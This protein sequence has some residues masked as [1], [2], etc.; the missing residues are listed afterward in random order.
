MQ[1][2]FFLT[3]Q[4][5]FVLFLLIVIGF[6]AGRVNLISEK[7]QKDITQL[8]LYITMPATIFS[9]MQLEMN[10]E[11]LN[12]SFV[13]LGVLIF[14]YVVMFIAG[15][16]VSRR[17]SLSKGQKDIFQTALLLSNTSFMGYPIILSLLGPDALFYA[18]VGAG[19]IFEIVSWSVGVYLISRN[20]SETTGFNWKKV[21]FSPGI[22]SI[23][24]GLIF[25]IFQWSV[26]EPLNSVIDTMSPATSP[27]AMIVIG[28]MLSRSNINEAF[29]NKYLYIAAAF[30]L[31]IV[32]FII[33]MVLKL[34]GLT[35]PALV[36]PAMMISMPTA[37]YVAMFSNNYGNDAKFASQIV[38]LSSL[39][40]MISIPI[41]TL[42]F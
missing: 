32:P 5:V 24:I 36:I 2:D 10:Q 15:F 34:F 17:L 13:I 16:L 20:G 6:I 22:L 21:L 38:F 12:T 40:S 19:F 39:M 29:K 14:C 41:I 31:L 1:I 30:K 37:S 3:L 4:K 18:V 33:T 26:P 11:R 23:I 7:G 35:G 42:L 27:L 9:A 8:V 28:L 25:F